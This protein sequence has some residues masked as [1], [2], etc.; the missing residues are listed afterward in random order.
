MLNRRL[1]G[2]T[3]VLVTPASVLPLCLFPSEIVGDLFYVY[4]R[5]NRKTKPKPNETKNPPS[6]FFLFSLKAN[7]LE[8][9][10]ENQYLFGESE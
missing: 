6:T 4:K 3:P 2:D 8:I 5:K 1:Y 7:V 10:R 9:L